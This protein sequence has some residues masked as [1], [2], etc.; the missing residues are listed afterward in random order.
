M[1]PGVNIPCLWMVIENCCR[2]LGFREPVSPE[3]T[4]RV[5]WSILVSWKFKNPS[6]R[7]EWSIDRVTAGKPVMWLL[8]G[9]IRVVVNKVV[10]IRHPTY[11]FNQFYHSRETSCGGGRT[12]EQGSKLSAPFYPPNHDTLRKTDHN[13]G[14]YV[15]YSLRQ[16]CG[17]FYVQQ[18]YK[19]WRV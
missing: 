13:T 10:K 3:A 1:N 11:L 4:F 17:F 5:K 14:M 12:T 18:D 19:H 16:V 7:F 9:A 15:P 2:R 6:E 8:V